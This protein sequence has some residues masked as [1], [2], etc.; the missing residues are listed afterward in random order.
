MQRHF[1]KHKKAF[2][3]REYTSSVSSLTKQ[4]ENRLLLNKALNTTVCRMYTSICL[5][6]IKLL[7]SKKNALLINQKGIIFA[8]YFVWIVFKFEFFANIFNRKMFSFNHCCTRRLCNSVKRCFIGKFL[9]L[10][11]R[12]FIKGNVVSL[13]YF[14][15]LE[16]RIFQFSFQFQQPLL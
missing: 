13:L 6:F 2:G 9:Q 5:P 12:F 7:H 11:C 16:Y 1:L 8:L 4:E 14:V 3:L 10:C 15:S